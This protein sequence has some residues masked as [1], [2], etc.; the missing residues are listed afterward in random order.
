MNQAC[1]DIIDEDGDWLSDV[2]EESFNADSLLPSDDNDGDT[3]TNLEESTAGTATSSISDLYSN[4]NFLGSLDGRTAL[5]EGAVPLFLAIGYGTNIT[6][7]T[8]E[9]MAFK[10]STKTP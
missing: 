6:V 7:K 2:W 4:G 10:K 3:Y 1:Y 8:Q 9:S 5:T